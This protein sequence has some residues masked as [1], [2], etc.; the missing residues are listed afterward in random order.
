MPIGLIPYN[1]FILSAK[2]II[3]SARDTIVILEEGRQPYHRYTKCDMFVSHKSL[4]GRNLAIAFFCRG[5]ERKRRLLA[6]D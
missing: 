6:E 2:A 5:E 1:F 4:N 3:S